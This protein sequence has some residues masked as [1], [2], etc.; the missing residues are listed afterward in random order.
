MPSSSPPA[1]EET[2][3]D[4]VLA[5]LARAPLDDEPVTEEEEQSVAEAREDLLRGEVVTHAE[6]VRRLGL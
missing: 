4:A 6:L 5:A 3:K 2:A 1:G